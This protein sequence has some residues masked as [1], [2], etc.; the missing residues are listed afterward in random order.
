MASASRRSSAAVPCPTS[1]STSRTSGTSAR[2]SPSRRSTR[3]SPA[4]TCPCGRAGAAGEEARRSAGASGERSPEPGDVRPRWGS[5]PG[6][7]RPSSSSSDR[8][9]SG[10]TSNPFARSQSRATSATGRPAAIP[11]FSSRRSAV[12]SSADTA[13]NGS[14]IFEPNR[15]SV[16]CEMT[17]R[18]VLR[19]L[20]RTIVAEVDQ[21]ARSERRVAREEQADV[22]RP[23]VQ[24]LHRERAPGVERDELLEVQAVDVLQ[25]L[26]AQRAVLALGRPPERQPRRV[27]TEVA[28]RSHVQSV[29]DR[30]R[31]GERV[32]VLG[33][34]SAQRRETARRQ[35]DGQA[36]MG[37]GGVAGGRP[38]E[39]AKEAARV[40]GH[41]L[42][43]SP[44][45]GGDQQLARTHVELAIHLDP[46]ALE[47]LRVDLGQ[48]L[49]LG[50]VERSDRDG[51]VVQ[52]ARD[53]RG[54]VPSTT[55]QGEGKAQQDGRRHASPDPA[56][57]T[58][59]AL[60]RR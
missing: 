13:F 50:E 17:G 4:R 14:A 25:P 18:D 39:E 6:S 56:H 15:S 28:Q 47:D 45:Q 36:F 46:A 24:R 3:P 9:Y 26:E 21:P 43:Q 38:T 2:R 20:E 12:R 16:A 44:L 22:D 51:V 8:L 1:R 48:H 30:R 10:G 57:R 58:T 23:V 7:S 55:D 52:D 31:D 41:Q 59:V 54:A 29:R 32:R 49:A 27:R 19:R 53:R 11:A 37:G 35:R 42:H 33:G 5:W 60:R 40:F 34:C